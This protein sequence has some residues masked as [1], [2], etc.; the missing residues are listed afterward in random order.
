MCSNY[1]G[2]NKYEL[3]LMI[4]KYNEHHHV[5]E[6]IPANLSQADKVAIY[7]LENDKK[8]K[9]ALQVEACIAELR[10]IKK[11]AEKRDPKTQMIMLSSRDW[12]KI[13]ESAQKLIIEAQEGKRKCE[14]KLDEQE[15]RATAEVLARAR[16]HRAE[17]DAGKLQKQ[18]TEHEAYL[19]ANE[20]ASE[21][22]K[23]NWEDGQSRGPIKNPVIM[24][25]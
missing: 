14:V 8:S 15:C 1:V 7:A 2:P 4:K 17:R 11:A 18:R 3:L 21:V 22:R 9:F 12:T 6:H 20:L 5:G 13:I 23:I 24:E 16:R 19:K 10:D 25:Y